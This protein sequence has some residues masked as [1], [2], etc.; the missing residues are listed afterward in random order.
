MKKKLFL[1]KD[2]AAEDSYFICGGRKPGKHYICLETDTGEIVD[3]KGERIYDLDREVA[4]A[5]YE[6]ERGTKWFDKAYKMKME[7]YRNVGEKIG[8]IEYCCRWNNRVETDDVYKIELGSGA[9]RRP[10][11]VSFAPYSYE[12]KERFDEIIS[13]YEKH[14][15]D[16][17]YRE[18]V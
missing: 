16:V 5:V 8:V 1:M 4:R 14:F 9:I 6:V 13:E 17:D 10:V 2:E 15:K 3:E 7:A 12:I 11:F 18:E